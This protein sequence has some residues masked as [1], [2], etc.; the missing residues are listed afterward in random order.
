[1]KSGRRADK[2]VLCP[3][4]KEEDSQIIF[5]EGVESDTTTHVAFSS[6]AQ[7][8]NY[9]HRFCEC[10]RYKRCRIARMLLQKYE[11]EEFY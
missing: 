3:F 6:K 2:A 10:D 5:W 8:K 7:I 9:K 11:E 4:Y 1:M